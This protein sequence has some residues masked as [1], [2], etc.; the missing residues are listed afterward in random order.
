MH[1]STKLAS[2][3]VTVELFWQAQPA[4]TDQKFAALHSHFGYFTHLMN[5]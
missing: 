4:N 3:Y 1:V 2:K 5:A